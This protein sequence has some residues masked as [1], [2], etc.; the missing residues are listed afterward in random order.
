MPVKVREADGR[1]SNAPAGINLNLSFKR[2][3]RINSSEKGHVIY[4]QLTDENGVANFPEQRSDFLEGQLEIWYNRP[5]SDVK[6]NIVTYTLE[7]KINNSVC[8]FDA[9][10][11]FVCTNNHMIIIDGMIMTAKIEQLGVGI[12]GCKATLMQGDKEIS[13]FVSE[14]TGNIYFF[15]V[16]MGKYTMKVSPPE[17]KKGDFVVYVKPDY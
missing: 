8:T 5:E 3:D 14:T 6:Q 13:S 11:G 9:Q 16:P 2:K 17:T 4:Q 15:G 12:A 7:K 10:K 1:L